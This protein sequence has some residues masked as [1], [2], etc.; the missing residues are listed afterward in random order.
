MTTVKLYLAPMGT[1]EVFKITHRPQSTL[2]SV[3]VL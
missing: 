1:R 2:L 3:T